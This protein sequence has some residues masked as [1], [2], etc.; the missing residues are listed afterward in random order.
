MKHS[1]ANGKWAVLTIGVCLAFV[2]FAALPALAQGS[3]ELDGWERCYGVSLAGQNDGMASGPE[4][5]VPG[6]SQT[7]YQGTAWVLVPQGECESI[8]TPNG[9]GSL[10]PLDG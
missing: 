10:T 2:S 3:S 8:E 7:D 1:I 4:E 9:R 6:S 5:L